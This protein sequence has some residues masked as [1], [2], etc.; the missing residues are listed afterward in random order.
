[1][2]STDVDSTAIL[3]ELCTKY[4]ATLEEVM[5]LQENLLNPLLKSLSDEGNTVTVRTL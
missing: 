4:C 2:E 1:M 3:E 5:A